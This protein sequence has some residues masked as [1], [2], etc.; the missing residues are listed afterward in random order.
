MQLTL[1]R[2]KEFVSI[3]MKSNFFVNSRLILC[4]NFFKFEDVAQPK[5]EWLTEDIATVG[6][7][8]LDVSIQLART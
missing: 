5:G 3:K 6:E 4:K 2:A 7:L 1:T 8:L